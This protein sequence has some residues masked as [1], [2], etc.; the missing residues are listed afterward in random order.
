MAGTLFS[1]ALFL[2]S[3]KIKFEIRRKKGEFPSEETIWKT[4]TAGAQL[5][6]LAEDKYLIVDSCVQSL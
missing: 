3:R 5:G 6:I 1:Y 4:L 2:N